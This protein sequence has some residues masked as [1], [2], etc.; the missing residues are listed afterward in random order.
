MIGSEV[1]W[2]RSQTRA[3]TAATRE[4]EPALMSADRC[5][6][7]RLHILYGLAA[8]APLACLPMRQGEAA[9]PRSTPTFNRDVAP[10]FYQNCARCHG[11]G[12]LASSI[13]LTSY[14]AVRARAASIRKLVASRAMPPW[15]VDPAR[16]LK[17]RNDARL[18][19]NDI[20]TI[21][22][23]ADA[24]APKGDGLPPAPPAG[25]WARFQG[26]SPDFIVALS[27]DMHIPAQGAFP[28][29]TVFVKVPFSED[30][31]I[32][33]SQTKPS[34]PAVVHHMALTE[35][36][37]PPGMTPADAQ[38]TAAQ[39]G[40]PV[41][42]FIKSAVMTPTNPSRP[43]M[44]SIYTPGSGLDTYSH[45]SGKLLKGGNN[46]YVIFNIH[47][48]TTGKPE[49]DRSKIALWFAS[50]PPKHQLYRVNG[51]G[52]T[53]VANGK[54]L[55]ADSPGEKAEGTHVAIPPLLPF[56][57]NYE[58][59]GVTAYLEPVTIYQFH[60][61]AHYRGKDF[62]YS[63]VYPDGHE[64]T[65]L[66]VPRFSHHWQMA[67]ELETPLKLPAGSKLIVTAH[68][69][70]SVKK[71]H[72]PAPDKVVYFRAMNQ[73]W[74]EMF[75]PFI[76]LSVDANQTDALKL[77]SVVGCLAKGPAGGWLLEHAGPPE[78]AQTQ[79]T[80]SLELNREKDTPLGSES[81]PLYG[82]SVFGPANHLGM[83]VAVKGVLL[84]VVGNLRV[85]VTSLQSVAGNCQ[86]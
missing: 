43:D 40:A 82:A 34:N 35:V 75:T 84:G 19:Q 77:G 70:N 74:D 58:L 30:R 37:I 53:I 48:Q 68:Y 72:N 66:S 27:G 13:P 16:S 15:P 60:P 85:N 65:L 10:I 14:E 18:S 76:Q 29:V 63:V 20:D 17:F 4:W 67:Y 54:E 28:Y 73:S 61:H 11:P 55:L 50:S 21:V 12:E 9:P 52:E 32:A 83:K 80:T 38:H 69:D 45:G 44:L 24:G 57:E 64:L 59:A 56:A 33:A 23:W 39:L 41:S 3:P 81:Y 6:Q 26:R 36:S 5:V 71:M 8:L 31:W 62:T 22:A 51:A 49:I 7:I 1:D 42:S 47:Y 79:G 46:M 78:L 2:S 86:Q 25:G